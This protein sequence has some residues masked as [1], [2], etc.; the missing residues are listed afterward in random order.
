MIQTAEKPLPVGSMLE[1]GPVVIQWTDGTAG[2]FDSSFRLFAELFRR[3]PTVSA[4]IDSGR[5]LDATGVRTLN[6]YLRFSEGEMQW[7]RTGCPAPV[8]RWGWA[9]F[10]A[11]LGLDFFR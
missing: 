5:K 10:K 11:H 8:S 3:G 6:A 1:I 4:L 7:R 9:G 2:F